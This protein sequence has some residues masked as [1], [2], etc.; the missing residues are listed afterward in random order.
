MGD[1]RESKLMACPSGGG[2]V[3]PQRGGSW[4]AP[5]RWKPATKLKVYLGTPPKTTYGN[6][7]PTRVQSAH[8]D[9]D[10]RYIVEQLGPSEHGP[11]HYEAF[12]VPKAAIVS[13]RNTALGGA[14]TLPGPH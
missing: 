14:L 4:M 1:H 6:K 9:R 12:V 11:D 8:A 3:L 7:M 10:P 2:G 13:R 5:A